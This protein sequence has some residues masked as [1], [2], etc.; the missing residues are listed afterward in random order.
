[1]AD[2]VTVGSRAPFAFR[3]T[4]PAL[5]PDKP[6]ETELKS[7]IINGANHPQAMSGV[8]VTRNVDAGLFHSWSDAQKASN[9]VLYSH[10][11]EMSDDDVKKLD[12]PLEYGFEPGLKRLAESED[13]ALAAKGSTITHA[14]VVTSAEMAATSDTPNDD[15]PRGDPD[16]TGMATPT[17]TPATKLVAASNKDATALQ[18][19]TSPTGAPVAPKSA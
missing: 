3:I 12:E 1:M 4:E 17:Q 2:T 6:G 7:T 5:N 15:T 18:G 14:G 11:F 13:A 19:G 9:S 10:V 16:P 8:G